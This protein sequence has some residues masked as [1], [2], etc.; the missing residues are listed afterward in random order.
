MAQS[1][2]VQHTSVM[3]QLMTRELTSMCVVVCQPE[4]EGQD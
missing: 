2:S 1:Q 3:D 4:E